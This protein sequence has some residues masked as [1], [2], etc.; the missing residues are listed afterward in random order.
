VWVQNKGG[1]EEKMEELCSC[2]RPLRRKKI[3]A[4]S[5][6]RMCVGCEQER[7]KCSCPPL[8]TGET[9]PQPKRSIWGDLQ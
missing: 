1:V 5:Y 3:D 2:G 9:I 6:W 8:Q 4:D 7:T